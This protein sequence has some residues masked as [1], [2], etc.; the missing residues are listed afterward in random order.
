METTGLDVEVKTSFETTASEAS[1]TASIGRYRWLIC[2][3]LFFATTVNYIDRQ[4]LSLLKPILDNEL[5][6]TNAEF[7]QVNAAFQAAYALGLLLFGKF[8]DRFG[9]KLGY[10]VSIAAWSLAAMAHAA[11]SGVAGFAMAR[12]ALGLGEGGNFPSAIKA[13]AVWFP[14][15]ERAFATALFNSGANVGAIVAPATIPLLAEAGGWRLPFLVAGAAGFV[16]LFF[17]RSLYGNPESVDAVSAREL[18]HINANA[19]PELPE[20]ER[21]GWLKLLQLRAAWAFIVAKFLTDPVWWFFLIWL[22]DYFKKTR[23]LDLKSSWVHLCSIYAIV[24][25]LSITGGWV[26]GYWLRRGHTISRARKQGMLLFACL[27]LPVLTVTQAS[28]WGAVMLIG[29]A[30]AAHQAWSATLFTSVSDMFPKRAVA[31]VVGL[32][33]M[34]GSLGGIAF[35]IYSGRLLDRFEAAG[36]VTAGYALLFGICSCAYLLAFAIHHAL[37]PRFEPIEA[38]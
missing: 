6:W 20:V 28:D 32:G 10:G 25:V 31:S 33:G 38:S 8:I 21:V 18:A 13:V 37:A 23:G 19:E 22:P 36:N 9:V 34:A 29:L 4:I 3:L 7:G 14:K 5:H 27:V 17:W 15:R 16:W 2:S 11:A 35:P 1:V 24:T 12:L 30:G 26:T